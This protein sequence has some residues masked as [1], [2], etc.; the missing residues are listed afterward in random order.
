MGLIQM[1]ADARNFFRFR[2]DIRRE[3]YRRDSEFNKLGLKR[4][5]LGNVVYYQLNCTDEDLMNFDYSVDRMVAKRLEPI[6]KY[7]DED[8][9]WGESLRLQISNF[10]DEDGNSTL[11][12][13]ALFVF[14][15]E[16][17]TFV[18]AAGALLAAAAIAAAAVTAACLLAK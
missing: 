2:R 1:A 10:V 6:I 14:V 3:F 4:N 11:S 16:E 17:L 12:Y 15:P 18:K 8:L 5:W 9:N 13:G 7:L